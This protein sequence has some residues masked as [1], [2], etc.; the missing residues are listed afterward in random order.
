MIHLYLTSDGHG[1][2]RTHDADAARELGVRTGLDVLD[3]CGGG[4][5][6]DDRD[7]GRVEATARAIAAERGLRVEM[8]CARCE[9][10]DCGRHVVASVMGAV[11]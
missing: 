1:L 2:A 7:G 11:S 9:R 6:V 8:T 4:A 10:G 5:G 3:R